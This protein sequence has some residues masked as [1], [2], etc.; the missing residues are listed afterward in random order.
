MKEGYQASLYSI[1][2]D[3]DKALLHFCG[4]ALSYASGVEVCRGR[5]RE[6]AVES[7]RRVKGIL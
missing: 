5:D 7:G 6:T 4:P 3:H 1:R 2:L